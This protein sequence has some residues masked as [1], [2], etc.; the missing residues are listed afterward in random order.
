MTRLQREKQIRRR[1]TIAGMI[2]G[3]GIGVGIC[4]VGPVIKAALPDKHEGGYV[5]DY[6]DSNGVLHDTDGDGDMYHWECY[7]C[8]QKGIDHVE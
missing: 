4:T 7:T 3:I 2:V 5:A 1:L 8:K 6:M